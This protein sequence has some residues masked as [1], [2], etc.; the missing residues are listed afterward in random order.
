MTSVSFTSEPDEEGR[1]QAI[2]HPAIN[3][4]ANTSGRPTPRTIVF[5]IIGQC[6]PSHNL[7]GAHLG[8]RLASQ[9]QQDTISNLSK[10]YH[11]DVYRN[12]A[13]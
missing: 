9:Y 8:L 6:E 12:H 11:N 1:T 3:Q 7:K 13:G 2:A 4:F 5:C 10:V